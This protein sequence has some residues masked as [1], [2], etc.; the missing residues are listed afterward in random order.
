M[1]VTDVL[2]DPENLTLAIVSDLAAPV[3]RAWELWADPRQLERWWGPPTYPATFVDHDLRPG[4]VVTYFM[5]S[6]EGEKYH[7]WWKVV[8]IETPTAIEVL[9]GF[10]N[11]D[12]PPNPDLPTTTMR[13]TLEATEGGS[14]MTIRSTFGST[15]AMEKVLSMGVV[16]GMTAALGQIDDILAA[17]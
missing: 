16:E 12:D 5:T 9:D 8:S 17:P 10:G 11:P 7:G 3:D 13:V 2:K 6:P 15:D 14:R 1:T 4:G